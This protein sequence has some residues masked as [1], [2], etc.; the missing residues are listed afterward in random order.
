MNKKQPTQPYRTY[1]PDQQRKASDLLT[2]GDSGKT[3]AVL[4]RLAMAKNA[5][6]GGNLRRS[7]PFTSSTSPRLKENPVA[8]APQTYSLGPMKGD[9]SETVD[10]TGRPH[11]KF[12]VPSQ[13]PALSPVVSAAIENSGSSVIAVKRQQVACI[14]SSSESIKELAAP[15]SARA[16]K[17]P[18]G[19]SAASTNPLKMDAAPSAAALPPGNP[20]GS[21]GPLRD[22]RGSGSTTRD[23]W[24][25]SA[26][27]EVLGTSGTPTS[28]GNRCGSDSSR[29]LRTP[30]VLREA[31][32]RSSTPTSEE[33][34]KR[35]SIE[36]GNF[37]QR[38]CF[39]DHVF[40]AVCRSLGAGSGCSSQLFVEYAEE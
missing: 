4:V 25:A 15:E 14:K 3:V 24:T 21:D 23:L 27:S 12:K 18:S 11:S 40:P 7:T 39:G 29:L 2:R 9:T 37:P 34:P 6:E 26:L 13:Q 16:N 30:N 19:A 20:R 17:E 5:R 32:G 36:G 35:S 10:P 22:S 28:E 8:F 38:V 33:N 31:L 1:N